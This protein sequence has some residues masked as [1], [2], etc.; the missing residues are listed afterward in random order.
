[1]R[2]TRFLAFLPLLLPLAACKDKSGCD[3]ASFDGELFFSTDDDNGTVSGTL[4]WPASVDEGL[5]IEIGVQ[6]E[7]NAYAGAIAKGGLFDFPETCGTELSFSI[8][9]VASGPHQ[10]VAAIQEEGSGGDSGET[11]YVAE[12][13]SEFFDV[14]DGAVS[15][16]VVQL[17]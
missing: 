14:A 17:E 11:F 6:N 3:D 2:T 5:L 13:T 4:K 10:V 15:G 16:I 12:G 1:M 9:G 7:N 8:D